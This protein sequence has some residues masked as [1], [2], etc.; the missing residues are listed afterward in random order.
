MAAMIVT[1][2]LTLYLGAFALSTA[3]DGSGTAARID[4]RVFN[5]LYLED[6]EI[7]G[8]IEMR[9]ISETERRGLKGITFICEV[10]GGLG[11]ESRRT[12][13]GSMDGNIGSERFVFQLRS[14]DGRV[15]PAVI[16]V[17]VCV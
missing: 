14:S 7:A 3:D 6:G 11:F 1:L 16:E 17:A 9:L 15:V 2:T 4:H 12:I 13:V 8:D 10:P 5:D